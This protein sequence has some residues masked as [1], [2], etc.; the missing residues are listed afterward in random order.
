MLLVHW[1][2]RFDEESDH[3]SRQAG[4]VLVLLGPPPSLQ[5]LALSGLV[6]ELLHPQENIDVGVLEGRRKP[7]I[8]HSR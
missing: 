2:E 7:R 6:E 5:V 1:G 3:Y 8:K 4:K